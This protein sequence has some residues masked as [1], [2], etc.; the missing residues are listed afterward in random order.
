[1]RPSPT[2]QQ[3]FRCFMAMPDRDIP[4]SMLVKYAWPRRSTWKCITSGRSGGRLKLPTVLGLSSAVVV[5]ALA[6]CGGSG[7][8]IAEGEN[9]G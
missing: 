8:I 2:N 4:T 1:M 6:G 7:T 3:V 9:R 5:V